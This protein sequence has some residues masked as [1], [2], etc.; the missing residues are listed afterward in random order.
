MRLSEKIR[1]L[2]DEHHLTQEQLAAKL[3]VSRQT[4]SKWEQEVT[5]P[6]LET[7]KALAVILEV[8]LAELLDCESL[9]QRKV[10][11]YSARNKTLYYLN[12]FVVINTLLMALILFR[13]VDDIIPAHYDWAG[14]ITRYGNKLEYLIV[15]AT[16]IVFLPFS[17]YF[18]YVL[19]KREDYHKAVFWGQIVILSFQLTIF[20]ITIM[21]GFI[22]ITNIAESIYPIITGLSFAVIFSV[23]LF[24]HP[25]FNQKRNIIFGVRT[26]FTLRN[27]VAW[28][29]VNRFPS[30]SS[31]AFIFTMYLITLLTFKNWNVYLFISIVVML[32]PV[33]IYHEILRKKF[34]Q[35]K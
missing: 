17:L 1:K 33:F 21:L 5:T 28:E 13:A 4:V 15:P 10:D 9:T 16:S 2:R 7:L 6:S 25:H 3:F 32:I 35:N 19:A 12:I 18:H 30:I 20:I 31:S 22:Y 29:K 26:S 27:D 24:S 34:K 14:N 23:M 11:K 8:S